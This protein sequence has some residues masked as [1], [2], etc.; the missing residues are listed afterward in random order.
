MLDDWK[1]V[2]A[3]CGNGRLF[4]LKKDRRSAQKTMSSPA[5]DP[6]ARFPWGLT[7]VKHEMPPVSPPEFTTLTH[8]NP[9]VERFLRWPM[10]VLLMIGGKCSPFAS[11]PAHISGHLPGA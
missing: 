1:F 8:N 5:L 11:K 3:W 6:S 4:W 7:P 2:A 10:G 9:H